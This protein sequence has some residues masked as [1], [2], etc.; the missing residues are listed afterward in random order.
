MKK[1]RTKSYANGGTNGGGKKVTLAGATVT[2]PK[3]GGIKTQTYGTK[4]YIKRRDELMAIEVAGL[5]KGK[6][7]GYAISDKDRK[8]AQDRVREKLTKE[9]VRQV[10]LGFKDT[11]RRLTPEQE[12][13]Y[14]TR[15]GK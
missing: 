11:G 1:Y 2:A 14:R 8:M 5:T 12:E 10:G 15:M 6:P 7:K 4:D 9:G 13:T 3:G